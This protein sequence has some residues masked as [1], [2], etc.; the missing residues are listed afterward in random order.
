MASISGE[1]KKYKKRGFLMD[2]KEV[3]SALKN[4]RECIKNKDYKEALRHCKGVLAQDKSNYNAFVFVGVA[5][6]GLEQADQAVKAYRRATE[7][8]PEQ[9]LAW[10][11]SYG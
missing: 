5:A 6:D 9:P 4:A 2:P 8:D 1:D 10:Q 11:V 7:V 3:K